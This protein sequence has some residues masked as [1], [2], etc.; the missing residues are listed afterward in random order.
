MKNKEIILLPPLLPVLCNIV[1]RGA[2]YCGRRM[3]IPILKL[4]MSL[5]TSVLWGALKDSLFLKIFRSTKKL[6]ILLIFYVAKCLL[7]CS[8]IIFTI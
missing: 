6:P 3:R 5:K 4:T 8:K 7:L 1:G 2:A